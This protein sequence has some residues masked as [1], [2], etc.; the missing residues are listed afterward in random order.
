M[1]ENNAEFLILDKKTG[2]TAYKDILDGLN[3]AVFAKVDLP[4]FEKFGEYS[5]SLYRL[6][7]R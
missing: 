1:R 7:G 4:E 6:K 3:A 5:L 2:S